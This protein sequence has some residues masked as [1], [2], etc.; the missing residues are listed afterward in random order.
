MYHRLIESM[1][2]AYSRRASLGDI[3][4]VDNA[5]ELVTNMTTREFNQRIASLI[6]DR[7]QPIDYYGESDRAPQPDHGTSHTSALDADGNGVSCTS[8]VNR[9][10][11]D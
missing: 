5:R 11:V 7:A 3:A 2:F 1:K 9:W 4:F 10:L 8:T 6:L